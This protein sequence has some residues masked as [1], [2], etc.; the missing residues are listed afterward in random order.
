MKKKKYI[1]I[2]LLCIIC[3]YLCNSYVCGNFNIMYWNKF[4]IFFFNWLSIA[5]YVSSIAIYSFLNSKN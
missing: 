5:L 4:F 1:I 3:S 2:F